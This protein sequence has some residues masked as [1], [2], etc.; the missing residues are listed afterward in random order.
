M[1]IRFIEPRQPNPT[2]FDR[3]LLPRLG[4]P[5]LG[6]ILR[7]AGHDVRIYVETLAAVDWKDVAGADLVGFSATTATAPA[8][9]TMARHCRTLGIPTVI[10]G[11]HVTFLAEEALDAC[12]YVVRGEGQVA[13]GEVLEVVQ[14]ARDPSSVLG[15]SYRDASGRSVHNA[16][17]PFCSQEE[18]AALPSPDLTLIVQ[19]ERMTNVPIMTQWGCPFD[20][21]FCSVI[22]MFGRRVRSRRVEDVL[23]DLERYRERYSV[24]FYDDNFV[25]NK[26]RTGR[27]LRGMIDRGF[28]M[29][30]SAQMRADS[31]YKNKRTREIDHDFLALMRASGC[32]MVYSG[33]ESV[34]PATLEAYNKHQDVET[35]RDAVRV[36][37]A[38]GVAVHGM[39]VVG[40]DADDAATLEETATFALEN[41]IDTVQLMMLTPCPGTE[42]YDRIASEGR[43]LTKDWSLYDGHHCLIQPAR[44]TPYQLQVGTHRAMARFYAAPHAIR[45]L[46][47][48]VVRNLPFLTNRRKLIDVLLVP[49]LRLYARRHI[50]YWARLAN[51]RAHIEFLRGISTALR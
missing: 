31:V 38:Y 25:V 6:R 27:L 36:L 32:Q 41:R 30:W 37:H 34:N 26:E 9:Y 48:N 47:R 39:F 4:L 45:I 17:R 33:F 12:D 21:D 3:A 13:I 42:F 23:D 49:V 15:L 10:G 40:S 51:S 28:T 5:L 50:R 24:F 8:S 22:K 2:V 1:K 35:I 19:H 18:L 20:C 44:M 29:R 46:I 14:G 43:L 16:S 7:E 11:S